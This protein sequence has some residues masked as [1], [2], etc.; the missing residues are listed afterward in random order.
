MSDRYDSNDQSRERRAGLLLEAAVAMTVLVSAIGLLGAQLVAG[1]N[2]TVYAEEQ[3]RAVQLVDRLTALLELDPNTV[4][5]F[6]AD[7]QADGD[8][9][10]QYP[11]WFWRAT[12]EELEETKELETERKL[13]RITLE[14]LYQPGAGQA[15]GIED[16][17]VVR[18][19]HLLK[20]APGMIDLEK[21][22]GVSADK[23]ETI[24]EL[25][26]GIAPEALT[27]TGEID[28]RILMQTVGL[29]DLFALMPMLAGM[30]MGDGSFGGLGGGAGGLADLLQSRGL[31]VDDLTG[32]LQGGLPGG[33]TPQMLQTF[34]GGLGGM[35][36]LG[37]LSQIGNLQD[38]A[39]GGAGL[40]Q[41]AQL[42]DFIRSQLGD[43]LGPDEL[44][45]LMNMMGS[46]GGGGR[47]GPGRDG[48]GG[49]GGGGGR[50]G[51]GGDGGPGGG[52]RGG[53][54]GGGRGG[55]GGGDGFQ[56][57]NPADERPDVRRL[58]DEREQRNRQW[59]QSR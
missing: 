34:L 13:N 40:G 52:G 4:A 57:R 19:L 29:Q 41:T 48:S 24:K 16:A 20:A 23:V 1:M 55:A 43:Q 11:E 56:G 42:L 38:L 36:G 9:G 27:E 5:R 2:M 50:G 54:G 7:R 58:A 21:H 53:P 49:F 6:V 46:L 59:R 28:L 44:N 33:I 17:R 12:A 39:G 26:A 15:A 51:P 37:D 10:K 8:F 31:S 18:R 14:I 35:Q 32:M 47:G 22:F 45:Q 30:G 3:T 25:L